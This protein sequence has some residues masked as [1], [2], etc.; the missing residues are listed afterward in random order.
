MCIQRNTLARSRYYRFNAT[1]SCAV[2]APV[3]VN[4]VNFPTATMET[5]QC[6]IVLIGAQQ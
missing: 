3:A 2:A 5:Q 4:N 6:V 1:M